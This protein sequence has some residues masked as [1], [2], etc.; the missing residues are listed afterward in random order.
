MNFSI[1]LFSSILLFLSICYHFSPTSSL[2]ILYNN[3]TRGSS[4]GES[5][6]SG[7]PNPA[8][9]KLRPVGLASLMH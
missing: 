5:V 2:I 7:S 3:F 4:S 8:I 1:I 9:P 6:C